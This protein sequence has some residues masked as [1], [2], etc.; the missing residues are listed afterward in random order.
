MDG[1]PRSHMGEI[2]LS[3]IG[4]APADARA[5]L[6]SAVFLLKHRRSGRAPGPPQLIEQRRDLL[7]ASVLSDVSLGPSH[8]L[9]GEEGEAVTDGPGVEEAHRLDVAGLPKQALAGTEHDRE[10]DQPQLVDQAVLE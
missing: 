9:V 2:G 5:L 6:S 7:G 1:T 4:G 3:Q 10:D 8:D